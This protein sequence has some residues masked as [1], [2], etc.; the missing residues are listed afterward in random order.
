[1]KKIQKECNK[2]IEL[3]KARGQ[4]KVVLHEKAYGGVYKNGSKL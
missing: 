4:Q 2:Q 1:M 3:S